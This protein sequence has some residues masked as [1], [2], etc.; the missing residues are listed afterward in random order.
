MKH[1]PSAVSIARPPHCS[2]PRYKWVSGCPL[3]TMDAGDESLY[4]YLGVSMCTASARDLLDKLRKNIWQ[5]HLRYEKDARGMVILLYGRKM[6][7]KCNF[8]LVDA[9]ILSPT[10]K[11]V[12]CF[13]SFNINVCP[14]VVGLVT[15]SNFLKDMLVLQLMLY[16]LHND[17]INNPDIRTNLRCYLYIFILL[18]QNDLAQHNRETWTDMSEK[19]TCLKINCLPLSLYSGPTRNLHCS[20][21]CCR[22]S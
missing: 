19:Q 18:F 5:G 12:L 1:C 15:F 22:S 9:V 16:V 2:S 17:K 13:I 21:E 10:D 14:V 7:L 11:S 4:N 3:L 6:L 20:Y 8:S